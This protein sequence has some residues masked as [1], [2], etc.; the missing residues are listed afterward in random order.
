MIAIVHRY[1]LEKNMENIFPAKK[2]QLL[3]LLLLLTVIQYKQRYTRTSLSCNVA[4]VDLKY[5]FSI[6]KASK[7]SIMQD[8]ILIVSDLVLCDNMYD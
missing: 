1:V 2:N 6:S 8:W 3:L 7:F 4:V 5:F